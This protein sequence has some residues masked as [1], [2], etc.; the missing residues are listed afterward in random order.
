VKHFL[1]CWRLLHEMQIILM[2]YFVV[3]APV[4]QSVMWVGYAKTA[5]RIDVL[6]GVETELCT[7]DLSS[8]PALRH[9]PRLASPKL[10]CISV[11]QS[12]DDADSRR[13]CLHAACPALRFRCEVVVSETTEDTYPSPQAPGVPVSPAPMKS[14]SRDAWGHKKHCIRWCSHPRQQRGGVYHS[15]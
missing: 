12:V 11:G 10:C 3:Q 1:H 5:E 13:C 9:C 7:G 14:S 4:C 6:F 2:D 8:T 15:L